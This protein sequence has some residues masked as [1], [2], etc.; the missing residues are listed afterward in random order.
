ML[1]EVENK[2]T[3]INWNAK[4]TDKILQNVNNI[5]LMIKGEVPYDRD[6]GRNLSNID[7]TLN[8]V[9]YKIIEETYDLINKYE[10]RAIVKN[11]NVELDVN[12]TPLIKVVIDID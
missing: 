8:S 5:L 7:S 9:R 10:P 4:G 2:E 6:L 1:Y 12:N 3:T 11:V